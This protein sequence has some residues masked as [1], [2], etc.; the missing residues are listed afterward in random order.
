MKQHVTVSS[1]TTDDHRIMLHHNM[2]HY[3]HNEYTNETCMA[4]AVNR[5]SLY[6]LRMR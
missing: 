2:S 3:T 1:Q 6:P 5:Y 4:A